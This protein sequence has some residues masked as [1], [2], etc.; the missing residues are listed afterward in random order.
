V[1]GGVGGRG[2]TQG[3]G[4]LGFNPATIVGLANTTTTTTIITAT[5]TTAGEQSILSQPRSLL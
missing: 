1:R 3:I 4:R 5:T 2:T